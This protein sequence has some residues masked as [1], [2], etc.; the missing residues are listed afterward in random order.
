MKIE[1]ELKPYPENTP[2]THIIPL[3]TAAQSTVTGGFYWEFNE[4]LQDR[5]CFPRFTKNEY[6][7]VVAFAELPNVKELFKNHNEAKNQM[8]SVP[9]AETE[10]KR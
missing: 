10:T 8:E 5:K 2:T 4:Y 7:K 1:L 3:L 9:G 6:A